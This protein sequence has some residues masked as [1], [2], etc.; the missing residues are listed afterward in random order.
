VLQLMQQAAYAA[1]GAAAGA[2]GAAGWPADAVVAV[3][4]EEP[5]D[6]ILSPCLPDA[7][8]WPIKQQQQFVQTPLLQRELQ[9]QQQQQ[10][11]QQPGGVTR[12]SL[13][14]CFSA[15][16][17]LSVGVLDDP[18]LTPLRSFSASGS[19]SNSHTLQQQQQQPASPSGR[20]SGQQQVQAVPLASHRVCDKGARY[21]PPRSA[22]PIA[23]P[24]RHGVRRAG[25]KLPPAPFTAAQLQQQEQQQQQQQGQL[26]M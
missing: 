7:C 1:A 13:A 19:S 16:T 5:Q 8:S 11:Q 21:T 3:S 4:I 12:R 10:Q 15:P 24:A 6:G 18:S 25:G 2:V 17:N 14:G 20:L 26:F 22:S 23:A 9:Q